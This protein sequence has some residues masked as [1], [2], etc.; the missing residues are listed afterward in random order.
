M[1]FSEVV[2]NSAFERAGGRCECELHHNALNAPHHIGRCPNT[3]TRDGKWHAYEIVP[4]GP[5]ILSNCKVLCTRCDEL[6]R[7][8]GR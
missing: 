3:F 5:D 4:G 2:R 8:Y 1:A 6:T 7:I